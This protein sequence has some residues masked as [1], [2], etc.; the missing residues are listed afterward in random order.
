LFTAC[1]SSHRVVV[2]PVFVPTVNVLWPETV[3]VPDEVEKPDALDPLLCC[4]EPETPVVWIA[5]LFDVNVVPVKEPDEPSV[6][7]PPVVAR[8]W[9]NV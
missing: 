9:K 6:E 3:V 4:D 8:I 5:T 7:L 1:I 2:L